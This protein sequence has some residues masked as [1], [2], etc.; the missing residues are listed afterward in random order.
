[1]KKILNLQ[2]KKFGLTS[3][4]L[5]FC[6][7]ALTACK[8]K[9]TEP[10]SE[11]PYYTPVPTT[12]P[13]PQ[14]TDD[15]PDKE[16]GKKEEEKASKKKKK[17]KTNIITKTVKKYTEEVINIDKLEDVD[18]FTLSGK[19]TIL[20]YDSNAS[21][22]NTFSTY[23]KKGKGNWKK[24]ENKTIAAFIEGYGVQVTE[25]RKYLVTA[26]DETILMGDDNVIYKIDEEGN[27]IA[28][29]KM[30]KMFGKGTFEIHDW[31]WY[32]GNKVIMN[33]SHYGTDGAL[34]KKQCCLVD[35]DRQ[36]IVK[37]YS[38]SWDLRLVQDGKIIG[39]QMDQ[40]ILTNILVIDPGTGKIEKKISASEIRKTAIDRTDWDDENDD[41]YRNAAFSYAVC[42]GQIYVKYLTGIYRY[43]EKSEK[44]QQL[45]KETKKF[46][47]GKCNTTVF[48]VADENHFYLM[49]KKGFYLY[50]CNT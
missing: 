3:L 33:I 24:T 30:T 2:G 9:E 47:M 12:P 1:M 42:E 10:V 11:I 17:I 28:S 4:I 7:L 34:K 31:Y 14:P 37:R 45:L 26:F 40:N 48:R 8:E 16:T 38:Q 35:I 19:G 50:S 22:S 21:D 13:T 5:L 49:G 27:E 46:T 23:E 41:Y 6:L 15:A 43:D 20:C 36:K 32:K 44:W 39:D 18:N 25:M 29:A